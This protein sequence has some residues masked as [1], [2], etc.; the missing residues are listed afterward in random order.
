MADQNIHQTLTAREKLFDIIEA[1]KHHNIASKVYDFFMMF[2]I[3]ISLVPLVFKTEN[4]VFII[5]EYIT[6]AIFIIDYIL[7]LITADLKMK[8][9]VLA[10]DPD[11]DLSQKRRVFAFLRYPITPMAIIDLVSIL[12]TFLTMNPSFRVLRVFRL[13]RTF[14][15]FRL[16]KGFRYSKN[17]EL[18]VQV[19]REQR[20]SLTAVFV[21]AIGYILIVALVMFNIEPDTFGNFLDAVYWST[22]SLTTVGYGDYYAL[23]DFGQVITIISALFGIAIV[24]LPTGIISAGFIKMRAEQR[25]HDN[26]HKREHENDHGE[27]H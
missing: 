17:F 12:P 4:Q 23:T 26:E 5:A 8:E 14:K 27:K 13:I 25:E 19:L 20:D 11:V 9:I 16:F 22:V 21:V 24:A 6:T 1:D 18:I 2:T 15:V 10:R 7:R 3:I